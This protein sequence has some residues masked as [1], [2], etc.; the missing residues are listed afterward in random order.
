MLLHRISRVHFW[1]V[2]LGLWGCAPSVQES[3]VDW[4]P[5]QPGD[6]APSGV[7]GMADWLDAPAGR[8]GF[9]QTDGKDLRFE[10]GTPLKFWGVNISGERAFSEAATVERWTEQLS[11]YGVNGVRFHKFTWHANAGDQSTVL[12]S[13]KFARFDHFQAHLRERGIYYGWSHIYGHKVRPADRE[14]LLSYDEIANLQYP[15]SHL[16]GTTS[17]LVNFA[18]DLQQLSIELTVNM[19]EHRNPLTGLRYADD[20]ALAFI[21]LQNEDNIFWS[22]IQRSLEQAPSYRRLLCEQFSDWLRAK[23][24]TEAALLAA[25]GADA[26]PDGQSLA[27][28]NI[29]PDPDHGRFSRAY[30][31][32]YAEGRPMPRH[33]LD[34][35]L[36]LYETQRAFYERFVA[37][38][39]ATGYRGV[40]IASCWQAGTGPAH[41]YNLYA[42]YQAGIIDRHNYSG[43]S[44]GH[45]LDTG[46]V[47]NMPLVSHPGIGLLSTG[48]QQVADRPFALSEWMAL[49]PNEWIA[50]AAPLIAA[51]GMGLQGWDASF[52][53]GS[54][55]PHFT[56]TIHS[57]GVYNV[58]SP[59]QLGLYPALARMVHRG[60]VEEGPVI[61]SRNVHIPSLGEGRLGF[62]E[63]V[64][65]GYDDKFIAGRW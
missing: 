2:L 40:I 63:R 57:P 4:F 46:Q 27:R 53:F 29:F 52:Q 28:R 39:R 34:K 22:A 14:R 32:A 62:L 30:E 20:P 45:R 54:D 65:Q 33:I 38:I 6:D 5:F 35:L 49:M 44:T 3:S 15:W 8:H 23:Y 12:D 59:T 9:V 47:N 21:E 24:R 17:S 25:W 1:T 43:G 31:S 50:E 58:T 13:A 19:L 7:T 55:F 37:A 26:L 61:A 11:K 42:D 41:F 51:Y 64:E 60:D 48:M 56:E 36:F 10:D 18:P 16:N